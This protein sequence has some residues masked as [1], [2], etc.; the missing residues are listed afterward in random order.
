MLPYRYPFYQKAEIE[1]MVQELLK[2]RL[3]RSSTSPFSS[4]V[5][6][7]KKADGAWRFYVDYHALNEITIK[8]KYSILVID[9][10][11]DE[12]HGSRYYSKLDLRS[13]I[14]KSEYEKATSLR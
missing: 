10:L 12:L 2:S 11:L 7:V 5:L 4:H 6:L 9:E 8:D 14:I 13:A 3:I 1:R